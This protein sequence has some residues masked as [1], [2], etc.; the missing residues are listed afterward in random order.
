MKKLRHILKDFF[1]SC[2]ENDHKPLIARTVGVFFIAVVSLGFLGFSYLQVQFLNENETFLSAVLPSVLVD[3]ANADREKLGTKPLKKNSLLQNAAQMK[4]DHMAEHGY[5]AHVSPNG[6]TPWYWIEE[7]GYGFITAG[8]NLAVHFTDSSNVERAWMNSPTHRANI[9]NHNFR[10]VGIATARGEYQGHETTFVVQMFGTPI[11]DTPVIAQE[12]GETP[13]SVEVV[14]EDPAPSPEPIEESFAT[15][16]RTSEEVAG[17]V[18]VSNIES[19]DSDSAAAQVAQLEDV[20]EYSTFWERFISHP[21][22]ILQALYFA[23]ALLLL[24]SLISMIVS[25]ARH[26]HPRHVVYLLFSL[27]LILLIFSAFKPI[28][29]PETLVAQL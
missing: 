17:A 23:L 6:T 9:L 28:I 13:E 12:S 16:E 15:I 20:P 4:A 22:L 25:E 27:I 26:K 24:V 8:E 7:A 2:E 21:L 1:F 10:E 5:F 14:P 3:L 18:G 19:Q 29:F 11:N